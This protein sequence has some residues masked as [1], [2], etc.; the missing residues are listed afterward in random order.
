MDKVVVI[1]GSARGIGRAIARA[2]VQQ[3]AKVIITSRKGVSC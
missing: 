1:I 3:G 2:C